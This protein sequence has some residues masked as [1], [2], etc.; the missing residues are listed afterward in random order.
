MLYNHHFIVVHQI[1][2]FSSN[3]NSSKTPT[4]LRPTISIYSLDLFHPTVP[5]TTA[6]APLAIYTSTF[7][8]SFS[9]FLNYKKIHLPLEIL[10][11]FIYLYCFTPLHRCSCLNIDQGFALYPYTTIAG[12]LTENK[13][14]YCLQSRWFHFTRSC[15]EH[16][17]FTKPSPAPPNITEFN[18]N[19]WNEEK[20]YVWPI[21]HT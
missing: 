3:T 8:F 5:S 20:Y 13:Y 16:N 9:L 12:E 17:L 1:A 6:S 19:E 15:N 7:Y 4:L 18:P 14:R 2:F 11:Q 21:V 10:C